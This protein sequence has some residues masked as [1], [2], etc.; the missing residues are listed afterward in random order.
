MTGVSLD[1][2]SA[3]SPSS[4]WV[5]IPCMTQEQS[6]SW[7]VLLSCH[8][9]L[10]W[11][12]HHQAVTLYVH[13]LTLRALCVILSIL[14]FNSLWASAFP[15]YLL[16]FLPAFGFLIGQEPCHLSFVSDCWKEFPVGSQCLSTSFIFGISVSQVVVLISESLPSLYSN[17]SF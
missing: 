1:Q 17:L 14:R 16:W 15:V 3:S 9:L 8:H 10:M 13:P 4:V 11:C 6:Q 7:V 5:F 2:L 12:H